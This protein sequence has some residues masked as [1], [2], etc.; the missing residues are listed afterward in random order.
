MK[1][2]SALFLAGVMVLGGGSQALAYYPNTQSAIWACKQAIQ[3][4]TGSSRLRDVTTQ[5]RG[6]EKYRVQGIVR[7]HG[8]PNPSFTCKV[9]DGYVT[10]LTLDGPQ[11]PNYPPY[12]HSGDGDAVGA[13]IAGAIL[14]GV[15]AAAASSH[16][17]HDDYKP[18]YG[19]VPLGPGPVVRGG[20]FSPTPGIT[21][22][23]KQRACYRDGRGYSA[24]W[25]HREFGW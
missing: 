7:I 14:G 1:R 18:H 2:I 10:R 24:R 15:I 21:C 23:R 6:Y 17:H 12:H 13:A 25:T 4:R 19:H 11:N 8:Q 20:R 16:H 22:Y 9:K 5:Q 3:E